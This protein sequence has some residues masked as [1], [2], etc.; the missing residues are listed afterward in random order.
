[1]KYRFT[2]T[3]LFIV[4]IILT[5]SS[6]TKEELRENNDRVFNNTLFINST[7]YA[8]SGIT[9]SVVGG[10]YVISASAGD[11]DITIKLQNPLSIGGNTL[12]LSTTSGSMQASIYITNLPNRGNSFL[13]GSAFTNDLGANN[14]FNTTDAGYFDLA[15]TDYQ[16]VKLSLFI[17]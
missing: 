4:G 11:M 14:S 15:G 2:S 3:L 17:P 7:E 8:I 10:E 12:N 6:C 16:Y 5:F 9:A 1:M 13:G